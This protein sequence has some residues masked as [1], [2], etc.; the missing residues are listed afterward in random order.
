MMRRGQEGDHRSHVDGDTTEYRTTTI[1]N[2][3]WFASAIGRRDL[4]VLDRPRKDRLG[5]WQEEPATHTL[6]GREEHDNPQR[7]QPREERN[8]K[9]T[10]HSSAT[11]SESSVTIVD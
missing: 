3:R 10:Y 8:A 2:R 7:R 5:T 6:S 1:V 9:H 11:V 4:H